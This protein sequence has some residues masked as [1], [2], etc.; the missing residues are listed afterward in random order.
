MSFSAMQVGTNWGTWIIDIIMHYIAPL[1]LLGAL[2]VYSKWRKI[3]MCQNLST[4]LPWSPGLSADVDA[5]NMMKNDDHSLSGSHRYRRSISACA[6]PETD[7]N[8]FAPETPSSHVSKRLK[9]Y[10]KA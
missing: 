7:N 2:L 6:A 1:A 5:G 9:A 3:K 8:A 4:G 10:S